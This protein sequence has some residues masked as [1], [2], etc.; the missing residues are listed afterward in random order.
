MAIP[1]S[2]EDFVLKELK[3]IEACASFWATRAKQVSWI[4]WICSPQL[5]GTNDTS[6]K[7]VEVKSKKSPRSGV[8]YIERD[9]FSI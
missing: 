5:T 9:P 1:I 4:S 8:C 7:V 3:E 2:E 6:Q